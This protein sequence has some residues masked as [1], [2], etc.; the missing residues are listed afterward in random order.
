MKAI[1]HFRGYAAAALALAAVTAQAQTPPAG[2]PGVP[3][4]NATVDEAG[5]TITAELPAGAATGFLT[6][7]PARTI[8]SVELVNGKLVIKW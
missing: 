1:L 7:S 4:L 2:L 5:R 8:T 6:I 3:F